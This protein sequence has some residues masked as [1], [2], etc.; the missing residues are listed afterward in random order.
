MLSVDTSTGHNLV[1]LRGDQSKVHRA[2]C[3]HL[4]RAKTAV[5]WV[6]AEGRP[7]TEVFAQPWNVPCK[8]CRPADSSC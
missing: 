5:P 1:R 4:R 6:W 2:D 8:T 7:L 3:I